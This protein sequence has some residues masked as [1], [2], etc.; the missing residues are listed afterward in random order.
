[1]GFLNAVFYVHGSLGLVAGLVL[2]ASRGRFLVGPRVSQ[3]VTLATD[4][5]AGAIFTL[6]LIG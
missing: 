2:W 1:M 6:G 3:A 4:A 5:F